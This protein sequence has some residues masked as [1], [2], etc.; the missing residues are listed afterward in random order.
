MPKKPFFT[1][2]LTILALI[3]ALLP[4]PAAA[5]K[6]SLRFLIDPEVSNF[7]D[8]LGRPLIQAA[9]LPENRIRFHVMLNPVLNAFALPSGDIVFHSGLLLTVD[10]RDQV[11]AV[12]AHELAHIAAGHHQQLQEKAK[13][14][15]LA[16]ILAA[17][18]GI[19][20]GIVSGNSEITSAAIAGSQAGATSAML[21]F[22]RGREAQSDRLGI[23]YL[24]KAG[25]PTMSMADFLKKIREE[26]RLASVP[27]PYLLTHPLTGARITEAE[28]Q[29]KRTQALQLLPDTETKTL[30][31]IKA[32]LRAA[33][34]PDPATA[35]M[36][37]KRKLRF[38]KKNLPALYGMALAQRYAGDLPA[39]EEI[40][41]GLV[42]RF[43]EDPF[44]LRERGLTRVEKGDFA[45]AERD[46]DRA[47]AS[48][49]GHAIHDLAYWKAFT[50]GQME[51]WQEAANLLYKLTLEK[52]ESGRGLYLLAKAEGKLDNMGMSHMVLGRYY[53]LA[54]DPKLA[55]VHY[56][57]ALQRFS[58]GTRKHDIAQREL[59]GLIPKKKKETGW[60][61]KEEEK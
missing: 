4:A 12:M 17:G 22:A 31:R 23:H 24:A 28:D 37:F 57:Q 26:Q 42:E 55:I 49:V 45:E 38:A 29:A 47:M 32:K 39:S 46:F 30:K 43:P 60:F 40:L 59:E 36:W 2:L 16:S 33:N 6:G 11:A 10:N 48:A 8:A 25:F 58:R 54:R 15:S 34:W 14:V 44:I 41:N 27:P 53:R 56:K 61:D 13:G 52:P 3:L 1:P 20:A 18:A 19:A 21:A 7:L 35:I 51:R 5:K 9:G 50:L